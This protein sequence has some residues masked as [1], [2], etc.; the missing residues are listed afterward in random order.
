MI[1]AGFVISLSGSVNEPL[2]RNML[3]CQMK[4]KI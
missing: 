2:V 1:R 4:R 3:I